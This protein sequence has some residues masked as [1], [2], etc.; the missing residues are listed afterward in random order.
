LDLGAQKTCNMEKEQSVIEILNTLRPA[1]EA[2]G[3]GCEFVGLEGDVVKVRF[4]GA[5][6]LC[7]SINLTLKFG[8]IKTLKEKLPWVTDV[9]KVN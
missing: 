2:D 1:M 4:K 9:V 3:G 7:P 6:L 8:L 5:C